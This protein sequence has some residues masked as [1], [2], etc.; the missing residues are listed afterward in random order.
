M[1]LILFAINISLI[2]SL[3]DIAFASQHSL[4]DLKDYYI[5][6]LNKYGFQIQNNPNG[7]LIIQPFQNIVY[8][9]ICKD[10][11]K[12]YDPDNNCDRIDNLEANTDNF[13]G[14]YSQYNS[15]ILLFNTSEIQMKY[16]FDKSTYS[17]N[18]D[19]DSNY[20]CFDFFSG[21]KNLSFNLNTKLNY[22]RTMT[23]QFITNATGPQY[24]TSFFLFNR[25]TMKAELWGHVLKVLYSY[26]LAYDK[27][28]LIYYSPPNGYHIHSMLCLYFSDN[29]KYLINSDI[30]T[31]PLITPGYF[32]FYSYLEEKWNIS[33]EYFPTIFY[34][35]L[36]SS[37]ILNCSYNLN[38]KEQEPYEIYKTCNAKKD[39]KNNNLFLIKIYSHKNSSFIKLK[40]FLEPK[41]I[42]E[43]CHFGYN[44]SFNKTV[45]EYNPIN[46]FNEIL[47]EMMGLTF[48]LYTAILIVASCISFLPL[49]IRKCCP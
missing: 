13:L 42:D 25:D 20:K 47:D 30:K 21:Y 18:I 35:Y 48:G 41:M 16:F 22:N 15:L 26:S 1:L 6:Y 40:L 12:V 19:D 24:N 29:Y 27:K 9:Y 32:Y 31:I 4:I 5:S 34:F 28:Y 49:I 36:D 2:L 11:N 14:L 37:K 3:K 8:F 38:K 33:S 17:I 10:I 43:N 45:E 44:V 46:H 39:E 23:F 7:N